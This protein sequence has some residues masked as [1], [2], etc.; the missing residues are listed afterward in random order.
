MAEQRNFVI[1]LFVPQRSSRLGEHENAT[2]VCPGQKYAAISTAAKRFVPAESAVL[3]APTFV[4]QIVAGSAGS[5]GES[6]A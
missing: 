1:L 5:A 6:E 3:V 2:L 4:V